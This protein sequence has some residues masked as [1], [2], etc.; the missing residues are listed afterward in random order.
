[1]FN[2]KQPKSRWNTRQ[3]YT[4]IEV[5]LFF[6]RKAICLIFAVLKVCWGYLFVLM[7]K[8]ELKACMTPPK[9]E[10]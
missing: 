5:H 2:E 6:K 4:F 3:T 10:I 9:L 8:T 7:M 1:M